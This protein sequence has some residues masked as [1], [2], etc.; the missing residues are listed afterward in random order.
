VVLMEA[1]LKLPNGLLWVGALLL[2][3]GSFGGCTEKEQAAHEEAIPEVSLSLPQ[4]LILGDSISEDYYPH[5]RSNLVNV[6]ETHRPKGNQG[7]TWDALSDLSEWLGSR[8]W[9][10]IHSN[11]GLHDIHRSTLEEY[12]ANLTQIVEQL[13]KTNAKLIF[14]TS[15]PVPEGTPRFVKGSA[16]PYNEVAR[17]VMER[18]EGIMIDDLH[19]FARAHPEYQRKKELHFT[20]QGYAALGKQVAT[21]IVRALDESSDGK[22]EASSLSSP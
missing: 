15:T 21:S 18:A 5:V 12:E 7:A 14:A 20:D 22:A 11:F 1:L 19:S 17:R 8:K 16:E 3:G 13:K 9:E 10:V 4:V 6:A 2:V